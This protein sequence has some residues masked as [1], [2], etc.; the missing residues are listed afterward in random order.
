MSSSTPAARH[1]LISL[2]LATIGIS[3]RFIGMIWNFLIAL[4]LAA[5]FS[6]MAAPLYRK[7]LSLVGERKGLSAALTILILLTA[8]IV[9]MLGIIYLAAVQAQGLTTSIVGYAQQ[10][11]LGNVQINLPMW[12]PFRDE[13]IGASAQIASKAGELAGRLAGFFVSAVSAVTRGTASFFLGLFVM[14]YAMIFFLQDQT[15]ALAKILAYS[16]LS[17]KTQETLIERTI[18]I[19]RA[20]IKGTLIIGVV[21]GVLG[22]LGFYFTGIEGAA[23]W[24]VVIAVASVIPGV[25]P[26]L[27]LI[28]GAIYLFAIGEAAYAIGLLAWTFLVVTTIDNV[29]RPYLVGHDTEMPDLLILISTLGGLSMFGAVGLVI[30]PVIAGLFI[31]IWGIFQETYR[32]E[33]VPEA[34]PETED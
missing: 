5:I 23:F 20:T 24:G 11:D 15:N 31:T 14:I 28:P 10:V 1:R 13:L 19:S 9:P 6:A 12:V 32:P 3:A 16:G 8:V 29:L 18:S 34:P 21:Q 30:G 2:G 26:P 4:F 25:G 27:I 22:G 17:K 33:T 7:I